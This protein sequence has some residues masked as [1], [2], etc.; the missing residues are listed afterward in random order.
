MT[1]FGN[2]ASGPALVLKPVRL[3]LLR[4]KTL[5]DPLPEPY[6]SLQ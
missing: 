6:V 5:H 1:V 4:Q 3:E 2:G